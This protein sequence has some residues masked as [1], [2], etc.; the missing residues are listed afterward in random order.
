MSACEFRIGQRVVC[1]GAKPLPGCV[2]GGSDP[3]AEGA[4]YTITG[5]VLPP[6]RSANANG[7]DLVLKELARGPRG[8]AQGFMGYG[9]FR[10]R[11]LDDDR[12]DI[13]IFHQMCVDAG[14]RV[15]AT[16]IAPHTG[17]P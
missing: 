16:T 6:R 4:T 9:D 17:A 13:S 1:V 8:R 2:W 3:P 5:I 15:P 14:K 11:S 12:Y 10:F 7:Y